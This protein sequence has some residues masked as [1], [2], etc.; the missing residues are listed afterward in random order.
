MGQPSGA[1][2]CPSGCH[3]DMQDQSRNTFEDSI[4]SHERRSEVERSS[5]D[6]QIVGV[7]RFVQRMR[8]PSTRCPRLCDR[9]EQPIGH[10]HNSRCRNRVLKLASPGLAPL[11]HDRSVSKFGHRDGAKKELMADE[12]GDLT[13]K[14]GST[15]TADCSTEHARVDNQP[16]DISA[17]ANA[18]S[19]SSSRST[20]SA[21]S[22]SKTGAPDNSSEVRSGGSIPT[23]CDRSEG[24]KAPSLIPRR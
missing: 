3:R 5:S 20:T 15:T 12:R 24:D 23:P 19:S 11:G 10:R 6:P 14:E 16:H 7:H 22:D 21:S 9:S 8:V 18:S 4:R 13:I 17:T 1:E 2:T